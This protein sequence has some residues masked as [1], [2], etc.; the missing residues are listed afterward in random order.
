[1]FF[2]PVSYEISGLAPEG[3]KNL[4]PFVTIFGPVSV[5]LCQGAEIW[6]RTGPNLISTGPKSILGKA[7]P[8]H[9]GPGRDQYSLNTPGRGGQ[10]GRVGR[11][12]GNGHVCA[13]AVA[14]MC[15]YR[16]VGGQ[17]S[18]ANKRPT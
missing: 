13:L 14:R 7:G 1:M 9:D 3:G 5:L 4:G 18:R 10:M 12:K 6:Y 11:L 15:V 16:H 2:G 17:R 8:S